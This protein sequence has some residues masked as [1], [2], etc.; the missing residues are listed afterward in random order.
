MDLQDR[1]T[2]LIPTYNRKERLLGTLHSIESQGHWGE[3]DVVIVDNCSNYSVEEAI[4]E[5]FVD[6]FSKSVTVHRWFFNTGMSTNIS[7]AFEFVRTKWCWFISDD[8]EILEGALDTILKD[9]KRYAE[10][11][12]VKYSIKDICNYDNSELSNVHEWASYY[13]SHPSGDKGYLSMLYNVSILYPYL[14]A[15]T[16]H[17]YSYLSFWLPVLLALNE[18]KT[19]MIMSSDLLFKYKSNND[20]WSSSDERYLNTLLGIRTLFDFR[21]GL[22]PK[23]FCAFKRVFVENLFNAKPV[24][25]RIVS[26]PERQSRQHYYDLLK[27][28]FSGSIVDVLLSKIFFYFVLLFNIP[29]A[30]VNKIIRVRNKKNE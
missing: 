9:T 10:K 11:I 23:T 13:L 25:L 8:D 6:D 16:V 12:A 22:P 19:G 5:E 15:L 18:T 29:P 26:L 20:G 30:S 4:K 21:Y 2:I 24:V 17:S 3:Y 27:S 7:I 28:Y 1:L 14:Q